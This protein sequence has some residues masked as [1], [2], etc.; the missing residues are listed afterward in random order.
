[1]NRNLAF[2]SRLVADKERM[3]EQKLHKERL[4]QIKSSVDNRKPRKPRV[5]TARGSKKLRMVEDK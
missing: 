4:R 2:S 1:M 3:R 5:L